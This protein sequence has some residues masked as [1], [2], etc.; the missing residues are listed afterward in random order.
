MSVICYEVWQEGAGHLSQTKLAIATKN[1]IF[2]YGTPK[3]ERAFKFIKDFYTPLAP[4]QLSFVQQQPDKVNA[5]P[6]AVSGH[7][8]E[9]SAPISLNILEQLCLFVRYEK[10]AGLIRLSDSAVSEVE[11]SDE[12]PGQLLE[13]IASPARSSSM[14]K[15]LSF[16]ESISSSPKEKA[17][18]LGPS[19][20]YVPGNGAATAGY[21]YF[22]TK[23]LTTHI[24]PS[25]LPNPISSKRP[26]KT[27]SWT[28]QPISV[29]PKLLDLGV[30]QQPL[31]QLIALGSEGIEVQELTF[32]F[33]SKG[34]GKMSGEPLLR[35]HHDIG[36]TGF[37]GFGGSW[38]REKHNT[39]STSLGARIGE[40]GIYGWVMK[41]HQDWR[42]FWLGGDQETIQEQS[43][44]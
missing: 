10:K 27:V 36:P 12:L 34:K 25:P 15:S 33:L 42:I 14:R 24:M 11:L 17:R 38:H 22:L 6:L 28:A 37:L 35:A 32:S 26:F 5:A 2:L 41:G 16:S 21:L 9:L 20:L 13:P 30:G 3:G 7:R 4:R 23:G 1:H 8:R 44:I 40:E 43:P 29:T 18:W 19:H 39:Y 31:L